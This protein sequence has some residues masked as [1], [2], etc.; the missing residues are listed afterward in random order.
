MVRQIFKGLAVAA[1]VFVAAFAAAPAQ[2]DHF[3]PFTVNETSIPGC[4][5]C[6]PAL[7]PL[8]QFNFNYTSEGSQILTDTGGVSYSGTGDLFTESGSASVTG[9]IQ[10]NPTHSAAPSALNC[11]FAPCYAI[12]GLFTFTGEA[13][14]GTVN[15]VPDVNTDV[16]EGIFDPAAAALTL[17]VDPNQDT[18]IAPDGTVTGGNGD[19]LQLAIADLISGRSKIECPD[20]SG[21]TNP[22]EANGDFSGLFL[23]SLTAFGKTVFTDPDPFYV[24]LD[25]SGNTSTLTGDIACTGPQP[26]ITTASGAGNSFFLTQVP[27]P[28]SLLLLGASLLTMAGAAARRHIFKA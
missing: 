18:T 16:I 5:G 27:Q 25:F 21:C 12:Y 1:V 23:V 13:N 7:G 9:W 4:I 15:G 17:W 6:N 2:A 28:A 22:G 3:N 11:G 14:F 24:F 20:L 10:N 8:G 26:C 19:D